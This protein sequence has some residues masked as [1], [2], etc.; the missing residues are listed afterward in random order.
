MAVI[1]SRLTTRSHYLHPKQFEL[2]WNLDLK[3]LVVY[4][5]DLYERRLYTY[6][7][8]AGTG[9]QFLPYNH[10]RSKLV[11]EINGGFLAFT[12]ETPVPLSRRVNMTFDFGPGFYIP[13]GQN[14]SLKVGASF[15]HFSNAFTV[16]RNPSFDTFLVYTA[17]TFRDFHFRTSRASLQSGS[18]G[19]S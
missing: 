7:G 19:S 5:N 10:W 16:K 8:G 6:G 11:L 17:Y 2:S 4:S 15:Y 13:A 12:K 14:R 1:G 18:G 9:L 3:P